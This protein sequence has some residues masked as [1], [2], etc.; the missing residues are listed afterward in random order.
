MLERRI[1]QM[2]YVI[3]VQFYP[4]SILHIIGVNTHES[5]VDWVLS[6]LNINNN[7]LLL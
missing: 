3:T 6:A 1:F 4:D 2:K 7:L 5:G